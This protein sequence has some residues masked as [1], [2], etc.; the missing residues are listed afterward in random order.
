MKISG[1][2]SRAVALSGVCGEDRYK[3]FHLELCEE[4]RT[5]KPVLE[6]EKLLELYN[7]GQKELRDALTIGI[8]SSPSR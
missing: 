3:A 7:N 6:Y 2:R 5:L 4:G 8:P 1:W